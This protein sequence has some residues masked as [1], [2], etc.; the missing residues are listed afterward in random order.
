MNIKST[1]IFLTCLLL[2][3]AFAMVAVACPPP[4]CGPCE[5]YNPVTKKCEYDCESKECCT[6]ADCLDEVHYSCIDCECICDYDPYYTA[7]TV[8]DPVS[9]TSPTD[10]ESFC[11]GT[12]D[13]SATCTTSTDT[14][15]YHRCVGNVWTVSS[16]DDPVTHS[17]SGAGTFDPTTGTSVTWT[18]PTT[19]GEYTITVTA[20]DSPLCNESDPNDSITVYVVEV[21]IVSVDASDPFNTKINYRTNPLSATI[22]SV[23]FTAPGKTD[24]KTNVSG[25]FY[26]TYDQR[27]VGWGSNTI[28]LAYLGTHV[29]CSVTKTEKMPEAMEVLCAYFAVTGVGLRLYNHTLRETYDPHIY[30]VAYSGKTIRTCN[31]TALMNFGADYYN[32]CGWTERHKYSWSGAETD[33]VSMSVAGGLLPPNTNGRVCHTIIWCI[34]TNLQG[35]ADCTGLLWDYGGG[36]TP[37]IITNAEVD[38]SMP[39]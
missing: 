10:G 6:G 23:T 39:E 22:P 20:S 4:Y 25:N 2:L 1:T 24:S 26:F 3:S 34:P 18:P 30:S 8:I 11:V 5:T 19:A 28:C 32:I 7:H 14:D 36:T 38:R 17:W 15:K 37:A 16:V 27:D 33:W 21:E 29:D 12:D 9:I 31:S 35:I 13:V